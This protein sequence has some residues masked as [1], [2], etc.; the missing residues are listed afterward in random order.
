MEV[1]RQHVIDILH[2]AGRPEEADEATRVLPDPVDLEQ[3]QRWA[4]QYGITRDQ[5]VSWMG[6]SS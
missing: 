4:A 3:V 2:R 1:S 5:L 6:G